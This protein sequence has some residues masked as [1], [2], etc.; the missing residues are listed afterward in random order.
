MRI[1]ID[2]RP[3]IEKKTGIGY[4][5][6]YLLENIL[7][8]DKQNEYILF[9][10]REV[11]FD[12]EKYKNVSI[13]ADEGS[14]LKKTFWYMFKMNKLCNDYNIDVFWG[15]QHVLPFGLKEQ[16]CILTVHDLVAFDFKETMNMYNR[17][18]NRILIPRSISKAN[19]IIA[20]SNSTKDRIK[21]HFDKQSSNKVK[22]IYEDV[23]VKK[24]YSAIDNNY[25]SSKGLKEKQYI[26]FLGTIEP[27]KNIITLIKSLE[28]IYKSTNMKLVICGKYGWGCEKER[29]LIEKN[30]DKIIFLN[31]ISDDEK[32]YLMNRSFAFIFPSLYEG[33]GLPVLEAMRNS[34]VT[35]VSDNT[36]LSEIVD[37]TL[38]KFDTLD[39]KALANKVIELYYNPSLYEEALNYCNSRQKDFDWNDISNQYIY[40][41]VNWEEE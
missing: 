21:F 25:L 39:E 36:S 27:R 7:N 30:K 9:S 16:K 8:N 24:N 3:L 15:T 10:D 38:I 32:D 28:C 33:F 6:K 40:E 20:V 14:R 35:I 11:F 23:I 1:G 31:Y 41:L 4:Y 12:V 22:V 34:T 2:A 13:I 29:E 37:N 17:I 26:L 18:I 5:L 19:K